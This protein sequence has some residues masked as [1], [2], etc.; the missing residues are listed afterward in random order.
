MGLKPHVIVGSLDGSDAVRLMGPE[1][2]LT[3]V[4]VITA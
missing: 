2:P 3:L 4:K 1:N